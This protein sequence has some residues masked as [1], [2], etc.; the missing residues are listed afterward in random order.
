MLYEVITA[1]ALALIKSHIK[2]HRLTRAFAEVRHDIVLNT[3]D[4]VHFFVHLTGY[5][6]PGAK[7]KRKLTEGPVRFDTL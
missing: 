1:F 3:P 6:P 2:I 5:A 7:F 4:I